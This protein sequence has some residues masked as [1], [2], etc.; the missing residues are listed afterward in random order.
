MG[1]SFCTLLC[2]CRMKAFFHELQVD[3]FIVDRRAALCLS[4]ASSSNSMLSAAQRRGFLIGLRQ[5]GHAESNSSPWHCTPEAAVASA[6]VAAAKAAAVFDYDKL[7]SLSISVT[8]DRP[9]PSEVDRPE[10]SEVRCADA[11][12]QTARQ[13]PSMNRPPPVPVAKRRVRLNSS[14]RLLPT[15][16]ETPDETVKQAVHDMLPTINSCGKGCCGLH[17]A[18][19]RF[20]RVVNTMQGEDCLMEW[21]P[22][23][24]WQCNHCLSMNCEYDDESDSE[25]G[26]CMAPRRR[27][28]SP[29][30]SH[31]IEGVL[32]CLQR[33]AAEAGPL[34]KSQVQ[35]PSFRSQVNR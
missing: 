30:P 14:G 25:C 1:P 15:F 21:K 20:L 23:R 34:K 8:N 7:G 24:D 35:L 31:S 18:L 10:P 33:Q 22:H 32:D 27:I 4:E 19:L 6:E 12:V 13:T 11:A 17:I 28:N 3:I 29:V 9:E 5:S 26:L 16:A 2:M